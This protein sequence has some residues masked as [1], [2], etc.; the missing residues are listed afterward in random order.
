MLRPQRSPVDDPHVSQAAQKLRFGPVTLIPSERVIL[1]DG[2]PITLTPKAFDLL[3]Y[4]ALHPGRLLT[5]DELLQ[6]IWPDVAVEESSLSYNVFAIR[7]AL[8][9]AE[10]EQRYIETVPKQGYRFVPR[11]TVDDA[12]GGHEHQ[13]ADAAA[14]EPQRSLRPTVPWATAL[15]VV[16]VALGT[17]L[18]AVL[19]RR[20]STAPES[21]SPI[22]FQEPVWG[23]LAESGAFSVSPDGQHIALATEG[24][25]G[26]LRY[27][28]R[29][30]NGLA[31]TP[32][33]G[34]EQ[35]A[36]AAP[37]IWSPDSRSMAVTG[38]VG[39]T[40]VDLSGGPSHLLCATNTPAVGG[41]GMMTA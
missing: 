22:R 15:I 10:A 6:S 3:T 24:P 28:T 30:L 33:Y 36:I 11:V 19:T 40:R 13:A 41:I 5:K 35:F 7:K 23:R 17:L 37:I 27:W 31:P 34:S 18:T 16:G 21:A 39:L 20:T 29:T 8:G 14:V 32:V 1:K 4:M 25:D 12:G 26:V 9:E 38:S 2:Q